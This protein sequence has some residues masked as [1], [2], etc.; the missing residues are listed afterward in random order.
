MNEL[1]VRQ[2]REAQEEP[3][4]DVNSRP[5]G[6]GPTASRPHIP[7]YGVPQSEEGMLPWSYVTGRLE[8]S[9][10]YWVC[11]TRPDGRP[12]AVP[13]WGVYV[14]G[15]LYISGG[16]QVR[17]VRNLEQNRAIAVHL[18]DGTEAVILEGVGDRLTSDSIDP[19]LLKRLGDAYQAKYE[20]EFG[21]PVWA[22]RPRLVLAWTKFPADCTRWS[23]KTGL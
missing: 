16:P 6:S 11:T 10:N 9:P 22:V 4:P 5:G 19:G 20:T 21:L 12:H 2:A 17:W 13:V 8:Q 1:N 7:E 3:M 23:F 15:T 18:E 14:D